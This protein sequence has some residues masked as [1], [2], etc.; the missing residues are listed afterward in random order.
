MK[1]ED[2]LRCVCVQVVLFTFSGARSYQCVACGAFV[3]F[4]SLIDDVHE[5]DC[6]PTIQ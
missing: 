6:L 5:T 2:G 4:G 3:T 1:I